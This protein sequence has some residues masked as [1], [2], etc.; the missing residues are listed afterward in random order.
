[1]TRLFGP[2]FEDAGQPIA[3]VEMLVLAAAAHLGGA[4]AQR[5]KD[6]GLRLGNGRGIHDGCAHGSA[7]RYGGAVRRLGLRRLVYKEKNAD[8]GWVL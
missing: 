4:A 2:A 6:V 1:M 7:A 5:G 8:F 3:L